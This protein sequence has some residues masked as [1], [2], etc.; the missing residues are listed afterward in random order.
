MALHKDEQHVKTSNDPAFDQFHHPG[1]AAP[2]AGVYR[3]TVCGHEIGI[4]EGHT[5]PPERHKGHPV[6]QPIRWRLLVFAEHNRD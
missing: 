3:C 4:A 6:G 5:L 2:Y 1:N